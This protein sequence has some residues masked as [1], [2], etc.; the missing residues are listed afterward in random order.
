MAPPCCHHRHIS[1]L[2]L[3]ALCF[4]LLLLLLLLPPHA[5]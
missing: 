5:S 3:A 1:W 4:S 2:W